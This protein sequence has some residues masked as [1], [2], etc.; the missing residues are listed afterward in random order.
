MKTTDDPTLTER[1][2]KIPGEIKLLVEKRAELL[3]LNVSE[4]ITS[5]IT[6]MIYKIAGGLIMFVGFIFLLHTLA[7]FIGDLLN[8]IIF[9]YLIVSIVTLLVGGI[10]FSLNPK[11]LVKG[12]KQKMK[13]PLDGA[14]KDSFSST[15]EANDTTHKP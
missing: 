5:A 14:I 8:N 15:T 11:N 7:L 6:K 3:A 10:I 9:G 4:M 12:T 1:L 2:R 13:E